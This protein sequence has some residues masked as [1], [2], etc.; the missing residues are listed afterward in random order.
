MKHLLN[1]TSWVHDKKNM[2]CLTHA[3]Q[4]ARQQAAILDE[5]SE[6]SDGEAESLDEE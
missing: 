5:E 1:R 6:N 2:Y 3:R 4:L